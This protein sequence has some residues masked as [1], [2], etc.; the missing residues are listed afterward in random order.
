ML[1]RLLLPTAG[2]PSMTM[3]PSC[4][5]IMGSSRDSLRGIDFKNDL[6]LAL[7]TGNT[8]RFE[9]LLTRRGLS[10]QSVL[11]PESG[12]S[13][14]HEVVS[15]NH[16]ELFR[17][18]LAEP[19]DLNHPDARGLTA[20]H[21]AAGLGR[22]AMVEMLLARGADPARKDALSRTALDYARLYDHLDIIEL[23]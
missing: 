15:L 13:V 7:R 18:C 16:K 8:D 6:W 20:L 4:I 14:L 17:A 3:R 22:R 5:I 21:K 12:Y 10:C 19:I 23:L 9:E 1:R 11:L 2:S